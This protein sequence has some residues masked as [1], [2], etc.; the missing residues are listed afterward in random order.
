M[1]MNTQPFLIFAL[2]RSMTAWTSCFLTVGDSFCM[3]EMPFNLDDIVQFME[4]SPFGFTGICDPG[5]LMRWDEVTKALPTAKLIYLR[6]PDYQCKRSLATAGGVDEKQL[7]M[8][9]Q[10]L[11]ESA[12][13]F[14]QKCEPKVIDSAKLVTKDGLCELWEAVTGNMFVPP[15][16]HVVKMLSLHVEQKPELIQ[17]ACR[18]K[19]QV[20]N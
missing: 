18:Q 3:H 12:D 20:Q 10:M 6:R 13:R 19:Q 1:G 9:F 14:I 5:L 11:S 8:G 17:A 2:P 4:N 7:E 15:M 16:L